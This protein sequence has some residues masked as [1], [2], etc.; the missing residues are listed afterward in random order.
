M[1]KR[2]REFTIRTTSKKSLKQLVLRGFHSRN[3]LDVHKSILFFLAI[4]TVLKVHQ[5][6]FHQVFQSRTQSPWS[7]R[8]ALT[9]ETADS[10]YEIAGILEGWYGYNI[11]WSLFVD[12]VS[13]PESDMS[14]IYRNRQ[15]QTRIGIRQRRNIA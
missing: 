9:K 13:I 7:P 8:S 3:Y 15:K 11:S 2:Q 6:T 1:T 12:I 14:D 5:Y 4:D 10:G